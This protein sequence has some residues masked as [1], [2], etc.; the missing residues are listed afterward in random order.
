MVLG[1]FELD[2]PRFGAALPDAHQPH[3][4]ESQLCERVPLC[5]GHF[6]ESDS[7]AEAGGE[8]LEPFPGIDFVE[9]WV[10]ANRERENE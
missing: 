2:A 10:R 7:A 6:C 5:I 8:F 1:I 3:D 9:V 4:I